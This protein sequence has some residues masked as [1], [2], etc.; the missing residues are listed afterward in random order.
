MA[1]TEPLSQVKIS[2]E[3]GTNLPQNCIPQSFT[4]RNSH[5]VFKRFV[6]SLHCSTLSHLPQSPS[7]RVCLYLD[8][9]G[10]SKHKGIFAF[11]CITGDDKEEIFSST[12]S[13]S[14]ARGRHIS[15]NQLRMKVVRSNS[16]SS[17]Y[18]PS[19]TA[20]VASQKIQQSTAGGGG[21]DSNKTQTGIALALKLKERSH[22][23][24]PQGRLGNK[25][26]TPPVP[27]DEQQLIKRPSRSR[28]E[29]DSVT[30]MS[31]SSSRNVSPARCVE[32]KYERVKSVFSLSSSLTLSLS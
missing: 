31:S 29:T 26:P 12:S 19:S 18:S 22:S 2:T 8:L 1:T 6:L 10:H 14:S 30:S 15:P 23:A 20:V 7:S 25:I 13:T 24:G 16:I 27:L 21:G 28:L 3:F 32:M 17:S 5:R 4:A 9:H 11:G